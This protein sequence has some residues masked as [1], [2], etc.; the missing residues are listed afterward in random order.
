MGL[1]AV[2]GE[3]SLEGSEGVSWVR[4]S[5]QR[6]QPGQRRSR[7]SQLG[8]MGG[9]GRTDEGTREGALPATAEMGALTS[10]LMSLFNQRLIRLRV[11]IWF[12]QQLPGPKF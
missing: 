11:F 4:L 2:T 7:K 6:E 9:G 5:R 12:A 10:V 8:Q 1:I 3:L